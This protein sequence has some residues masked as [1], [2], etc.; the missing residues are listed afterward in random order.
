MTAYNHL[1]YHF[2]TDLKIINRLRY[3]FSFR[4]QI[5]IRIF[6]V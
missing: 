6:I 3:T 1:I 2:H 4:K 5:L